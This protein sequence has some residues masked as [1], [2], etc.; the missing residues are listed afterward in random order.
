MLWLGWLGVA[1]VAAFVGFRIQG[2]LFPA[3]MAMRLERFF[4][5]NPV[6]MRFFGPR[7]AL[8]AVSAIEGGT[9]A[10]VG[11][12]IGVIVEELARRVGPSGT[13]WGLDIQPEA[14]EWTRR[15]LDRAHLSDR[16]RLSRGDARSLPWPDQTVDRL[17]MVAMLGEVPAADR[18]RVLAEVKRV[19][20]P[21]AAVTITEFWPDPHYLRPAYLTRLLEEAGFRVEHV[22]RFPLIYTVTARVREH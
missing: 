4:L 9:V 19:L 16:V 13:V 1:L 5:G 3:P 22:T 11:V 2:V 20:R 8:A 12:G 17:V 6:R 14:L 7:Q 18:P 10:E 15:R 21:M